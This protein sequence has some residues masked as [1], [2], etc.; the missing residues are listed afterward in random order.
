MFLRGV[1]SIWK[2][3]GWTNF[4]CLT[5]QNGEKAFK[6]MAKVNKKETNPVCY[7]FKIFQAA[8]VTKGK[9][10]ERI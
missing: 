1:L 10:C 6:C 9:D 8:I 2:F 7:V 5:G 4:G 3:S